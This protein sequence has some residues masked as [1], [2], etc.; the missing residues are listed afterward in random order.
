MTQKNLLN[1]E[2]NKPILGQIA[3]QDLII[4]RSIKLR[5]TSEISDI[6]PNT[7]DYNQRLVNFFVS[8]TL[9][10]YQTI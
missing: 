5:I 10:S 8:F 4:N 3:V 1:I 2:K 9:T 6:Q 7:A